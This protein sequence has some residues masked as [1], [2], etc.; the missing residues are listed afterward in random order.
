[1][2]M[3]YKNYIGSVDYSDED[4]VLHGRILNIDALVTFEATSVKALKKAFR[5]AVEDY[6]DFCKRLNRQPDRPLSGRITLRMG[7]ELHKQA[8]VVAA[9]EGKSLNAVVKESVAQYITKRGN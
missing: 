4:E 6:L 5:D 9:T 2:S 1:M 7:P 3:E 8:L